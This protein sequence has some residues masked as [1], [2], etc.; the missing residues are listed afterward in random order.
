MLKLAILDIETSSLNI[1]EACCKFIGIL[2]LQTDKYFFIQEKDFNRVPY[3]LKQYDRILT[4][5]GNNFDLPILKNHG[6]NLEYWQ[7][8]D[9]YEIMKKRETLFFPKGFSSL[10]LKNVIK[11]LHPE[12]EEQKID[13][14]YSIFQ[15]EIFT[16]EEL[17]EIKKYLERDLRLTKLLWEDLK[18]K[19]EPFKEFVNKEDSE[20]LKYITS[21]TAT[22]GYKMIC[23]AADIEEKWGENKKQISYE[24]GYVQTPKK[25][26]SKGN[27]LYL[28]FASLYPMVYIHANLFSSNCSCCNREQ[29]W[30]GH[31]KEKW[32]PIGY[33]CKKKQGKIEEVIKKFYLLR[34]EYKKIGDSREQALKIC[35]NSLYGSSAREAFIQTYSPT[36]ASD[37]CILAQQIIKYSIEQLENKNF[38][39]A[40]Y[41]DTDSIFLELAEDKT[42]EECLE[43][44]KKL[45]KEIS[46]SFPFPWPEE[47]NLKLED[48]IKYINFFKDYLGVLKK[49]NYLYVNKNNKLIVK[50]LDIIQRDC[51]KLSQL[52]FDKYLKE[53]IIDNLDCKFS[54]EYINSLIKSELKKDLL[55]LAK[56]FTTRD[57]YNS[58]TTIY[59]D[60]VEKYGSGEI[61]LIK[62][63]KLGAGLNKIKYCSINESKNLSFKDLDL[64]D[65]W[66]ELKPFILNEQT[67]LFKN[68]I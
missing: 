7:S 3:L 59:A 21:S 15:K 39:I 24:G 61:Y 47:F 63:F 53:Q 2:D 60:I 26:S 49:K 30:H 68:G 66:S 17:I 56:K 29:K 62:N 51:S 50:G 35:L 42:K 36:T 4:Y 67:T 20:R 52:I 34:K 45:S 5:N 12:N 11:K 6:I 10:S 8:I 19:F 33:Y 22:L 48:E 58:A 43:F 27:I 54:F 65:C 55:L 25:E 46:N 28:D 1:K 32:K 38:G 37:C 44:C 23:Y 13:I 16:E 64:S 57:S 14:D 41:A 40:L 9:L 31:G 18:E